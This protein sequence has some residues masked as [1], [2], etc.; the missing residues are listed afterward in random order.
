MERGGLS[1]TFFLTFHV[2]AC[3]AGLDMESPCQ[4]LLLPNAKTIRIPALSGGAKDRAYENKVPDSKQRLVIIGN[5][6]EV[7]RVR[8][9]NLDPLR[10]F[11]L[12]VGSERFGRESGVSWKLDLNEVGGSV[13]MEIQIALHYRAFS[14]Q[15][16]GWRKT[17]GTTFSYSSI[18][19]YVE[20]TL[21]VL[22]VNDLMLQYY[23]KASDTHWH[24]LL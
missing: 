8:Q 16:G 10:K 13:I 15:H 18:E 5:V 17:F 1:S 24:K 7:A 19:F 6:G 12:G 14:K 23:L 20:I 4:K 11:R 9:A 3:L 21:P 22:Y 2:A